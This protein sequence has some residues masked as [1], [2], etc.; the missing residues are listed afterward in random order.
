MKKKASRTWKRPLAG[1]LTLAMVVS[2]LAYSPLSASASELPSSEQG[3]PENP[4]VPVEKEP[5]VPVEEEPEVPVEEEPEVPAEEKSEAPAGEEPEIPAEEEDEVDVPEAENSIVLYSGTG[6]EKTELPE[7]I[8]LDVSKSKEASNLDDN[9]QSQ[10]TLSLPAA[11]YKPEIDVVF[12]IDDTS[13]TSSIFVDATTKMLEELNSKENLNVNFGLVTFDSVARDWLNAT[14]N[15]EVSGLVSLEDN[16]TTIIHAINQ[17]LSSEGTGQMKRIGGSNLEWPLEMAQDMLASGS[18]T[19]KHLILFSDMY[20]YV[21][22]GELNV[23]ENV[24][25]NVPLSKRLANYTNGQLCISPPMYNEWK[26]VY[27]NMEKDIAEYDSFFRD[28]EWNNYWSI[29]SGEQE[30]P[31]ISEALS[32]SVPQYTEDLQPYKYFTP[33]EKSSCLTYERIRNIL[34]DGVQVTIVNNDFNPGDNGETIQKIKDG[35][36]ADLQNHGVT[37]IQKETSNGGTFDAAQMGE[38]FSALENKLIQV[39]DA[40]SK[41]VDEIGAGTYKGAEYNFDFVNDESKLTL[42]VGEINYTASSVDPTNGETACYYF[43][44]TNAAGESVT[45][46]NGKAAPFILRYYKNGAAAEQTGQE[47][48]A[49]ECFVWEINVPVTK[50]ETVQLTYTVT[51]T[52]PQT[53]AGTYGTYDQYGENAASEGLYT[54]NKAVLYPVDTNGNSGNSEEFNKPTVSYTVKE[55]TPPVDPTPEPDD[56][57]NVDKSATELDKNDQTTV[58]LKVGAGQKKEN[59]AVLFLLDKSTSQGMRDEAAKMLDELANKTNTNILYDVV[60]FSGTAKSTGWNDIQDGATLDSIK[61]EFVNGKTTSGTNMAAGIWK[62]EA[63]MENL[64]TEHPE[65]DTTYL[66]TL[67]DGITYVWSEKGDETVYCVPVEGLGTN[68]QVEDSAQNGVDTWSMMYEYG[69]GLENIYTSGV[70]GFLTGIQSKMNASKENKH[71]QEYYGENSLSNPIST[72]IYNDLETEKIAA[73]YACGPDFAMYYAITGYQELAAQFTNTFAFA[74]PELDDSG[75]DNMTTWADYPWGKEIMEYCQSISTN[76]SW[77]S[78]VSNADA[79][80]IFE[81]IKN[82]ILYDIMS[83]T[84]TDVISSDFDLTG[85]GSFEL[86]VGGKKLDTTVSGNTVYFGEKTGTDYPYSVTYYPNGVNGDTR[87][88]FVWE[89]N[90]PVESTKQLELT[91][92]LKLVNKSTVEGSH[93]ALTNE[94]AV[95]EYTP[96]T[97]DPGSKDF[98]KPEVTYTVSGGGTTTP[99]DSGS[100]SGGSGSSG[101]SGSSGSSSSPTR[102]PSAQTGDETNILL[103]VVTLIIA[104]AVIGTVGTVYYKKKRS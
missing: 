102:T 5:E 78:N 67:S 83:G 63:D 20:G 39:V 91:Y 70:Q 84:V 56:S 44:G 66:V 32:L 12:V 28:S 43:N 54:N 61:A 96:T 76:A 86:A 55:Q 37:V 82:V 35:M 89:I 94:E 95:I 25:E 62:A 11:D 57:V 51:L 52:N 93:T 48:V 60:I 50:D 19:E 8:K 58:T 49:G 21:Y 10:I 98:P 81:G 29:Y 97:G 41:V 3:A 7:S 42:T 26:D 16:Y 87:E 79:A 101:N 104:A 24:Y 74:V 22:R 18:G 40:G 73:K 71:V 99:P 4:E 14:T 1:L 45:A 38:V 17:E 88:Q 77:D 59:V 2:L 36:L 23:G 85:I 27:E 6:M 69:K 15:G 80:K 31:D 9:Y 34:G 68:G 64:R 13:S 90:V 92:T 103:P 33:F 100:G 53:T 65:Y 46:T 47:A 30:I 75:N 72:Y